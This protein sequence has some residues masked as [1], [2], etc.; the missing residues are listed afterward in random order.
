M[1]AGDADGTLVDVLRRRAG[2]EPDRI[3]YTYVLDGDALEHAVTYGELETGA[4]RIAVELAGRGLEGRT[5]LLV[6]DPGLDFVAA[7][8]GC[9]FAGVIAVPVYPPDPRTMVVHLGRLERI[10]ADAGAAIVL[11][12][13]T[14]RTRT[15]DALAGFAALRALEWWSVE[16]AH[17]GAEVAWRPAAT[18]ADAVA[19]LQ[20]TSGS[21][22]AP[23][24][25][26]VTHANIL[27]H[28]AAVIAALG[29]DANEVTVSWLPLYHDMGLIGTVFIPMQLGCRSVQLS[30]LDFLERPV[31]WL[32]AITRHRGTLSPA[33]NF[34]F[35]LVTRRT[36]EAERATLDLR[37]WKA[38]MNGAEPIRAET[39]ERFI[40]AFAP[41][42]FRREALVPCYGLA[43]AT[44]MVAGGPGGTPPAILSV[45]EGALAAHRVE[46]R[47][48]AAARARALVGCGRVAKGLDVVIVDPETRVRAAASEVGE[49]WVAGPQV[50]AGYWRD[51]DATAATFQARLADEDERAYLRTGDL[52]FLRDGVLF[53]TGRLKDVIIVR[54]RNL[55]PQDLEHTAERAHAALRPGAGAA[56]VVGDGDGVERLVLVHESTAADGDEAGAAVEAVGHAVARDHGVEPFAVVLI[57]PRTLP[58]TSSGKVR[59]RACRDAYVAGTLSRLDHAPQ[60]TG[61]DA[62]PADAETVAIEAWLVRIVS[63]RRNLAPERVHRDDV[64]MALGIDSAE[65]AEVAAA[66]GDRLGR[67]VPLR[68]LFEHPTIA[69]LAARLREVAA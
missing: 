32:R 19:F 41:C 2:R 11:T 51:A 59:R 24:G 38:A 47:D 40:A 67:A 16:G 3:A 43:E 39:C 4:R 23:K 28:G 34:A 17:V 37:S 61:P 29:L 35:E 62:G 1:Y 26:V 68:L 9:F 20:Y 69:S 22:G 12:T 18:T 55:Y 64:L 46:V 65:A 31:R 53:V 58:K 57:R 52:G 30:P 48:D 21:T 10:A 56:F 7:I 15:A 45:D 49:I 42:G 27:A 50:A 66:L 25:V 54:G 63:E 60:T 36:T 33:P 44:L 13:E 14:V 8:F 5:A 6:F